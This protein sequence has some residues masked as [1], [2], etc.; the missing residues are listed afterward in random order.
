MRG[1]AG[2][3]GRAGC[4]WTSSPSSRG[5][6]RATRR[7]SGST[8]CVTTSTWT[9]RSTR[10]AGARRPARPRA[11]RL[12]QPGHELGRARH[13]AYRPAA[14]AR[15][16]AHL[17]DG[18]LV[19]GERRDVGVARDA[20]AEARHRQPELVRAAARGR[21]SRPP[22]SARAWRC[23][24][25]GAARTAIR[26]RSRSSARSASRR[27][28][29]ARACSHRARRSRR[30]RRSA[31]RASPRRPPR[32]HALDVGAHRQPAGGD[33][34]RSAGHVEHVGEQVAQRRRRLH[35]PARL[36][37]LGDEDVGAVRARLP[38][39]GGRADLHDHARARG[40]TA[41]DALAP[42]L[43]PRERHDGHAGPR[44]APRAGRRRRT[45]GRG[46]P[47]RAGPSARARAR[48]AAR[49][50]AGAVHVHAS[51]PSAPASP[52]AAASS[53]RRAR[54]DRRL[55]ERALDAEQ[56]AHVTL[57]PVHRAVISAH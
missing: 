20:L 15:V 42:G 27:R 17:V 31:C 55:D 44:A 30:W 47:R 28:R 13:V 24:G 4:R 54:A 10:A 50:S 26:R 45:R 22:P 36:D 11:R 1:D 39:A 12:A 49:S 2:A 56:V 6:S 35:V 23:A 48:P 9:T 41:R 25:R 43:S 19:S 37:A 32:A 5:R 14:G 52:T 29:R 3:A 40:M 16:E 53:G 51:D 33:H 46:W 57:R 7:A 8:C 38:R 21:D 34:R 18:A